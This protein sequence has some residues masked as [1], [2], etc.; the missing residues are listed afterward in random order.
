MADERPTGGGR[1]RRT[2]LIVFALAV[3]AA[4]FAAYLCLKPY[5]GSASWWIGLA[6]EESHLVQDSALRADLLRRVS[7]LQAEHGDASAALATVKTIRHPRLSLLAR[8]RRTAEEILAKLGVSTPPPPVAKAFFE[9]IDF[10]EAQAYAKVSELQAANGDIAGAKAT[11]EKVDNRTVAYANAMLA[12]AR[13][14]AEQGDLP[15]AQASAAAIMTTGSSPMATTMMLPSPAAGWAAIE[16]Y[17]AIAKAQARTGDIDAARGTLAALPELVP[18]YGERYAASVRLSVAL[19][20]AEGGDTAAARSVASEIADPDD[21]DKLLLAIVT[22]QAKASRLSEA[23]ATLA[24]IEGANARS[25]AQVRI[26]V[27]LAQSG[28]YEAAAAAV[29]E[30]EGEYQQSYAR[31]MLCEAQA[32]AGDL[33]AALAT[34]EQIGEP[35]CSSAARRAVAA[36]LAAA[37]KLTPSTLRI[38]FDG[39]D[40]L[41]GLLVRADCY[42]AAG[43]R[44]DLDSYLDEA[45]SMARGL[46]GESRLAAVRAVIR[47]QARTG[48]I[49][50]AFA[51]INDETK[52]YRL[53]TDTPRNKAPLTPGG[54]PAPMPAP[55]DPTTLAAR[56]VGVLRLELLRTAARAYAARGRRMN[57]LGR[58]VRR[59]EHPL[60]RA[61][62]AIGAARGLLE[63]REAQSDSRKQFTH[64]GD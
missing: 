63:G 23:A 39:S 49:S 6:V 47:A 60:E 15:G 45:L 16:A 17:R 50:E 44:D 37:G 2:V 48:R 35:T 36:R 62:A 64:R 52:G 43:M 55:P 57:L 56:M 46:S 9:Q 26:A 38:L 18:M 32:A 10:Q 54:P 51:I 53:G 20:I 13:A 11:L 4:S 31:Q 61:H 14:Q 41:S 24:E 21:R 29:E 33:D 42:H 22:A 58:T 1:S 40:P 3:A 59:L 19:A 5:P 30:I 27:A 12:I 7:E 25:L 8:V 28:R 34:L